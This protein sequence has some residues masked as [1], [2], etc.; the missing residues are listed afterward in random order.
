MTTHHPAEILGG[1]GLSWEV[2]GYILEGKKRQ[3]GV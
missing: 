1:V 3:Y 2:W